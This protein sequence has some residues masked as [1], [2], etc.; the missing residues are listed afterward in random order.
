MT[1]GFACPAAPARGISCELAS[2]SRPLLVAGLLAAALPA[3]SHGACGAPAVVLTDAQGDYSGDFIDNGAGLPEQDL[4]SL[5][6]AELAGGLLAFTLKVQP[7]AAPILPPNAVW[8]TSFETPEGGTY[9]I[10]L[11]T[12]GTGSARMY[13]YEVGAAGL[14]GDGPSDGRF[15]EVETGAAEPGSGWSADGTITLIARPQAVGVYPP[16]AGQS[17]GPFNAAAIQGGDLVAV[18]FATPVDTMPDGLA[19]DGFH[20]LSGCGAKA[21]LPSGSGLLVGALPAPTLL[22]L[23]FALTLNLARRRGAA[24]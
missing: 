17:L 9:G 20:D 16:L 2:F 6:V 11:E 13:S 1:G 15:V 5:E 23:L 7:F 10:R 12:D 4:L 8:Y 18:G 22:V 24:D 14:E 19:R 21:L 3:V